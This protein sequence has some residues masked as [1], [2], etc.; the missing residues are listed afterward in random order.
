MSAGF[1]FALMFGMAVVL[2]GIYHA[3]FWNLEI[4]DSWLPVTMRNGGQENHDQIAGPDGFSLAASLPL[5]AGAAVTF[6]LAAL[7]LRFWWWPL[8]PVGYLAANVWGTQSWWMPMF[9]GWLLK[10]LVIRYGG[11]RLYQRT[12]PM[13]VGAIL[14]DRFLDFLWPLMMALVRSHG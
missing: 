9:V 8:H 10:T 12:L 11:L 5:A 1:V 7:R 6:V 2:R 3:G 13:A 14:G 4:W